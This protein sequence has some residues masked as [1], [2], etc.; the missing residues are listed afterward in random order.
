[1]DEY[2]LSTHIG[3]LLQRHRLAAARSRADLARAAGTTPTMVGHAERGRAKIDLDLVQSL[4]AGL[5]L[6]LR[7]G[8]EVVGADLDA[9]LDRLALHPPANRLIEWDWALEQLHPLRP[10]VDGAVA[11]LLHG[12]PLPAEAL[13]LVLTHD[14]APALG[15]WLL[16]HN[17]MRWIERRGGFGA[18]NPDP[19]VPGPLY[20]RVGVCDIR[21]QVVRDLPAY[22][23]IGRGDLVHRVRPLAELELTDPAT[24]GLLCRWR[25]R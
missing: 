6:R 20:W 11:A 17:A 13:D 24:A 3:G 5:A 18:G 10:V 9:E 4:F 8:V 7:V 23:E 25:E 14:Q 2:R 22:L 16:R 15:G 12:V 19:A 21:V 1:V